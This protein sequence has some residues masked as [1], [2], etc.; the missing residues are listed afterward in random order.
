[1]ED[2][3]SCSALA[4]VSGGWIFFSC[5][6]D[7]SRVASRFRFLLFLFT[8]FSSDITTTGLQHDEKSCCRPLILCLHTCFFLPEVTLWCRET[9]VVSDILP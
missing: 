5:D 9:R 6:Y 7:N 1:M 4:V 3:V 8:L 2:A